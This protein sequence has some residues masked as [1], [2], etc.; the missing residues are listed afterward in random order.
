MFSKLSALSALLGFIAAVPVKS[1][2]IQVQVGGPGGTIAYSPN[3]VVG[4]LYGFPS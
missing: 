3:N 4:C 2:V 1:A